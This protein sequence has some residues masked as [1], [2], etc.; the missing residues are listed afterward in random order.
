M[1]DADLAEIYAAMEGEAYRPPCFRAAFHDAAGQSFAWHW[2]A[3]NAAQAA[4]LARDAHRIAMAAMGRH[5]PDREPAVIATGTDEPSHETWTLRRD[6]IGLGGTTKAAACSATIALAQA[7][8]DA[9]L[10]YGNVHGARKWVEIRAG[11]ASE[12]DGK[13]L[14]CHVTATRKDDGYEATLEISEP[15]VRALSVAVLKVRAAYPDEQ[16]LVLK[17]AVRQESNSATLAAIYRRKQPEAL[18]EALGRAA[19]AAREIGLGDLAGALLESETFRLGG[20]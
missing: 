3:A 16:T 17:S 14:R 9:G 15:E 18:R 1:V 19:D 20:E 4:A 8:C 12:S 7:L 5:A 13:H 2:R 6:L 10:A 11:L